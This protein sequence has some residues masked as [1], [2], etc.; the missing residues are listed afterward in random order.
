MA[1]WGCTLAYASAQQSG[2]REEAARTLETM[3]RKIRHWQDEA[4]RAR[5][6]AAQLERDA[7]TWAAGCR[8]GRDD[9]ITIVPLLVAATEPNSP[10]GRGGRPGLRHGASDAAGMAE[11][12]TA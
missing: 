1:A 12:E 9:V 11:K 10:T 7:E 4:A 6:H 2:L 5:T 3:R 8:Q